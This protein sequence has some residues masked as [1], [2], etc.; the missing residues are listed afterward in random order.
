MMAP[1]GA[2]ILAICLRGRHECLT[3]NQVSLVKN[4]N[5]KQKSNA[6]TQL[7]DSVSGLNFVPQSRH[8]HW[9]SHSVYSS[10]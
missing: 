7:P 4:V 9:R 3:W 6:A 10:S 2:E 8:I 5:Q 1:K